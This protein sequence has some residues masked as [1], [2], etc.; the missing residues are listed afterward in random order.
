MSETTQNGNGSNGNGQ[1]MVRGGGPVGALQTFLKTRE[2][3]LASYAASRIKPDV[4]IRLALLDFSQNEWLRKCTPETIYASLITSAQLG[5]EIGAA[6]GEA[7]LV[8]FKGKCTLVPGYRGLIKLALR[9]KAVKSIYSH[10]VHA[11]D[12]FTIELGSEPRVI[13][14]PSLADDRGEIIGAYAVAHM[15]NGAIDVEWMGIEALERIRASSASGNSGPYKDWSDQMYRKAPI[16][17]LAKRLPLGDDFFNASMVD[18]HAEAGKEPPKL[19]LDSA[20]DA[21]V[22]DDGG[23]KGNGLRDRVRE[24]AKE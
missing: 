13:H 9:S 14:R 8:P 23:S 4:L 2:K 6:K 3:S 22:V 17:R 12:E 18:E 19:D 5:L 10:I 7:Y 16:R 20:I 1:A 15:E 11:L 21:E 24:A